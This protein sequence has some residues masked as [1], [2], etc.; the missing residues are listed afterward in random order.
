MTVLREQ[1]ERETKFAMIAK[2]AREKPEEIFT[3]LAHHMN[4]EFLISSFRKLRK[5]AASGIDGKT[6]Y[7]YELNLPVKNCRPL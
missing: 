6:C 7:D 1:V 4:E 2:K 3:S 5:T